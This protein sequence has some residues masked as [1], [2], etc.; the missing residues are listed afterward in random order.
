MRPEVQMKTNRA[1]LGVYHLLDAM[2]T[3]P[4][5]AESLFEQNLVLDGPL[6]WERRE[7]GQISQ[8]L[9]YVVFVPEQHTESLN[10]N[11]QTQIQ[12]VNQQQIQQPFP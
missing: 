8:G 10:K 11:P 9:L 4:M 1:T 7:I 3:L 5:E 6:V 2:E 12:C